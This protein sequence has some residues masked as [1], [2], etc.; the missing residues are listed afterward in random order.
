VSAETEIVVGKLN[1]CQA[2]LA[3][4]L[5][6]VASSPDLMAAL[7]AATKSLLSSDE[8]L[9][10]PTVKRLH[11]D[12]F[13]RLPEVK[14]LTGLGRTTIYLKIAQGSFPEQIRLG[15]NLV[16]WHESEVLAWMGDR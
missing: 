5:A 7:A 10:P 3:A 8:Q 4:L 6:E 15:A 14:H 13:I 11:A 1:N 16:A 2:L 12:R 9:A